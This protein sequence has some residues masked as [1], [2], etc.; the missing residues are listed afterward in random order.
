VFMQ[1]YEDYEVSYSFISINFC[2]TEPVE[3]WL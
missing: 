1:I 2:H 3:V